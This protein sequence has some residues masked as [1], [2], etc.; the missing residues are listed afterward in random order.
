VV[1]DPTADVDLGMGVAGMVDPV[2][3]AV[4]IGEGDVEAALGMN[5]SSSSFYFF[6]DYLPC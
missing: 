6:L 3:V 4:A 5:R 1:I 2:V